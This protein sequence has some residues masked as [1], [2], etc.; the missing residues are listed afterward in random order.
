[1]VS[2]RKGAPDP[3]I[4]TEG[5]DEVAE[6][7]GALTYFIETIRKD[8]ERRKRVL[9]EMKKARDMTEA[10]SRAKSEFLA[11]M[12]HELRTPL[13]A[14]LGFSQIQLT[15]PDFPA[16][17]REGASII[18]NSGEHLL[19]LI[20]DILDISRIEAGKLELVRREIRLPWFI[21]NIE[22]IIA[23]RARE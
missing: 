13:N 6:M 17:M 10:A 19:T 5:E 11:N 1:M 14:I 2:G 18:K 22:A 20:T 8:N 3:A 7:A 16:S 9:E 15:Q 21:D 12:S 4:D 23:V